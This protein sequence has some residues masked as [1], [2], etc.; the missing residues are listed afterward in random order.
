MTQTTTLP[1]VIRDFERTPADIVR[2]ASEFP[3]SILAD[4]SGRRGALDAASRR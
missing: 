3:S 4:V 2:Q 1:D